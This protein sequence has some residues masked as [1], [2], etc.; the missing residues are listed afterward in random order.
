[1]ADTSL[2]DSIKNLSLEQSRFFIAVEYLLSK[3]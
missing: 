2:E 3:K 1:M